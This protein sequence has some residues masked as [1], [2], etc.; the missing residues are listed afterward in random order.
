MLKTVEFLQQGG[1]PEKLT[2]KYAIAV[3]A[4]PR[5]QNLLL[6]KYDQLDSPMGEELVQECRGLILDSTDNWKVISYPYDKFFSYGEGHAKPI[7]WTN[8]WCLEKL[9]GSLMVMY[10][11]KGAWNVSSS[12]TPAA[13]GEV[14]GF[15]MTLADLF[16]KTYRD[17]SYFL[18]MD[19]N[20]CYMFEL[21]S[22]YNR[23]VVRH[24]ESRLVLH[25]AR[26][27][28]TYIEKLPFDIADR[29]GWECVKHF[30]F[31][32]IE[33]VL[34]SCNDINPMDME[35]YVVCDHRFNRIKVKSPQYV[36]LH[37]MVES[38]SPKSIIK[39]IQTNEHAEFLSYFPE[40]KEMYDGLKVEYD[41]L[42]ASAQEA[43]D[44]IEHIVLQ[45]EFALEA[46]KHRLNGLMFQLRKG[47]V[48]SI[49]EGLSKMPAEK[50]L[51]IIRGLRESKLKTVS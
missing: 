49:S 9:D 15:G 26:N 28:N 50:V 37:H 29:N 21:V 36:A 23:I 14:N 16:W 12:G 20:L 51:D 5:W 8:C 30:P 35:G 18:P 39:I 45:K 33:E 47:M 7:D 19:T 44:K 3:K 24:A 1:T 27:V 25:G 46:V 38:S 10:F 40:Y 22:P 43:Y 13:D 31:R 42:V 48:K 11:Y 32:S 34:K 2:E 17:S 6:F 4:H 41:S